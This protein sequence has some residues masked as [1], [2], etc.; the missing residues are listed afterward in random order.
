MT[1]APSLACFR[2]ETRLEKTRTQKVHRDR[3]SRGLAAVLLFFAA[4]DISTDIF[5]RCSIT[6]DSIMVH[7]VQHSF[8]CNTPFWITKYGLLNVQIRW[9]CRHVG[10]TCGAVC[11]AV[12]APSVL[13]TLEDPTAV[14]RRSV[15]VFYRAFAWDNSAWGRSPIRVPATSS[16]C[17]SCCG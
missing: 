11:L 4:Y 16:G 7:F 2:H 12:R 10:D 17:L 14:G 9:L 15:R 3:M 1:R 5:D 13:G 6:A 8:D